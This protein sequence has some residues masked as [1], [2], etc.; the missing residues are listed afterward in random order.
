MKYF[1]SIVIIT[2]LSLTYFACK[3]S[4]P[5]TPAVHLINDQKKLTI[6]TRAT[7][8][9]GIRELIQTHYTGDVVTYAFTDGTF[10]YQQI[11]ENKMQLTLR[12]ANRTVTLT[13]DKKSM[14]YE[15]KGQ[16]LMMQPSPQSRSIEAPLSIE[17][18]TDIALTI[19]LYNELTAID[20]ERV[21]LPK[22]NRLLCKRTAI[23]IRLTKS[24]SVD[25]LNAFVDNYLGSHS[26]CSRLHGVD[27]GCLWGDYGCVST[28][29]IQCIC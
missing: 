16:D 12:K 2:I 20:L 19:A 23:S 6:L 15:E 17:E 18:Q 13:C 28:Q 4:A 22:D 27:T 5:I 7:Q 8:N 1:L 3:K 11:A 14:I 9:F 26:N 24:A 25:H 21:Q 10:T 29:Q